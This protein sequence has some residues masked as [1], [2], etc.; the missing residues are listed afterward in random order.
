MSEALP[1]RTQLT[2]YSFLS[3][4]W[5]LQDY[6]YTSMHPIFIHVAWHGPGFDWHHITGCGSSMPFKILSLAIYPIAML[7]NATDLSI[8]TLILILGIIAVFYG[9]LPHTTPIWF[10]LICA[11]TGFSIVVI[12]LNMIGGFWSNNTNQRTHIAAWCESFA[13]S[14]FNRINYADTFTVVSNYTR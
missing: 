7:P 8:G 10:A 4:F 1:S 9:P 11:T 6:L 5:L 2:H 3:F 12:N 13:L 14:N